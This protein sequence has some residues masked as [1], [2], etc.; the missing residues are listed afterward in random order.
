MTWGI[1]CLR[2]TFS[3]ISASCLRLFSH[4]RSTQLVSGVAKCPF[5]QCIL[6]YIRKRDGFFWKPG[7][8]SPFLR[9]IFWFPLFTQK[10]GEHL[11]SNAR[12]SSLLR[13]TEI[14]GFHVLP[15]NCTTNSKRY[16]MLPLIWLLFGNLCG[17]LPLQLLPYNC[18]IWIS[19]QG[20]VLQWGSRNY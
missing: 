19:S 17:L 3:F 9:I 15:I 20:I 2:D 1:L 10:W 16:S 11:S 4:Y 12:T 13:G 6:M 14:A 7:Q 8:K 18:I 5:H